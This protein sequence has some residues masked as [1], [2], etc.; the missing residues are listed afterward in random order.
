MT[1]VNVTLTEE[2]ALWLLEAAAYYAN[3][4][5]SRVSNNRLAGRLEVRLEMALEAGTSDFKPL[6]KDKWVTFYPS[7]NALAF[8]PE[9]EETATGTSA[10]MGKAIALSIV[11]EPEDDDQDPEPQEPEALEP[12]EELNGFRV[13]DRVRESVTGYL[14]TVRT[15][16]TNAMDVALDDADPIVAT[17]LELEHVEPEPKEPE[18]RRRG[19]KS[20]A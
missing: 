1:E 11:P 7:D 16:Y 4:G 8:V 20:D 14:G 18:P 10:T 3:H 15:V 13:G 9:P 19:R 5:K 6:P 12:A 2:E 17:P